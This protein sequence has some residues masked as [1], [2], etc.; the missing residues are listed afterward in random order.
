MYA[1]VERLVLNNLAS[2]DEFSRRSLPFIKPEYFSDDGERLAFELTREFILEHKVLPSKEALMIELD[3]KS[4]INGQVI[5]SAADVIDSIQKS[6]DPLEFLLKKAEEF[7]QDKALINGIQQSIEIIDDKKSQISKGMIPKILTDALAVSF[8]DAIGHDLL[9]DARERFEFYNRKEEKLPFRLSYLNKVT[10]GG[11]PRKTLNCFIASSGVGKSM[12]MCDDALYKMEQ[13]KNVL[14]ITLEMAEERIAER[15]DAN[16]MDVTLD[17][18]SEMTWDEY[19]KKLERAKSKIAGRLIV[20]EYPTASANA[21]HFRFL[22]N[23]LK[24]KKNFTPDVIYI[25]YL[26]I[27][28]SAR[29][30]PGSNVNSYTYIKAIAEELR[31][32]A[33]EFNVPI[34]TATQTNRGGYDNSDI[35]M[36]DTS[37]SIGLPMTLDTFFALISTEELE[38]SG[39][40]MVKQ[41]KNRFGPIDGKNKRFL[42]GID[43]SKMRLFDVEE[44]EQDSIMKEPDDKP[45]FDNTKFGQ[46][47]GKKPNLSGF[48]T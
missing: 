23:D 34:I 44:S 20:K 26:N 6:T 10:K 30:K 3:R 13:G 45:A 35:D 29:V 40:L 9:A 32:L 19:N 37:E 36:T 2:N 42:V 8:D 48:Q 27:C 47:S 15:I 33:V 41:L 7:C 46:R 17:R 4:G 25:D 38:R 21:S 11:V 28:A 18:L 43:R 14:Y 22:L 5:D 1:S 12:I 16:M 39:Q 31:G 24:L